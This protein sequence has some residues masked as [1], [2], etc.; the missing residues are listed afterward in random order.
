VLPCGVGWN[1]KGILFA[2]YVRMIRSHKG[3]D[4]SAELTPE[5]LPFLS[6]RIEHASWYS[7]ATFERFGNA[8]LRHVAGGDLAAVRMWGRFSV[9]VLR[10]ANPM[11]LAPGDPVETLRRFHVLRST[12]FDF[13]TLSV[14]ELLDEQASIV[15][16]YRM[17]ATAEEAASFQT[18]GFFER[19][20]ELAGARDIG[21][22]FTER[23]W[24]GEPR[25]LL[26]L[27][28]QASR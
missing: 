24:A 20:L 3:V 4:W 17:G 16:D 2:D 1:V 13:D 15:I 21:A 18:M 7:M 25:T 22:R 12:Y 28:W 10:H 26:D 14:A 11:L 27:V 5:D 19:L 9:D 8:I 23:A 6:M